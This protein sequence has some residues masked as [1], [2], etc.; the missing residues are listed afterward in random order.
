MAEL[1]S[2]WGLRSKKRKDGKLDIIGKDDLGNDYRVRQTDGP[3]ITERDV[4]EIAAVDRERTTAKEFVTDLVRD[5][6]ARRETEERVFEDELMEAAGPVV[7][8]G[9]GSE[10]STV[11]YSRRYA[12]NYSKAFG[13]N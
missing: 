6:Q 13:E 12:A 8:A 2:S 4:R 10:R 11:G 1:P 3:A 5:G 7:R 9:L